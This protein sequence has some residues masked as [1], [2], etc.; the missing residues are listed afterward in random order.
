MP[1]GKTAL[2]ALM[3][4]LARFHTASIA[5]AGQNRRAV[6]IFR[7]YAKHKPDIIER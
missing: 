7:V 3:K 5:C 1:Q 2:S 4:T 6:L